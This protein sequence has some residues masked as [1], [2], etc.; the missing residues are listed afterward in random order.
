MNTENVEQTNQSEAEAQNNIPQ[1]EAN[2][3]KQQDVEQNNDAEKQK[4]ESTVTDKEAELLK[5]VMKHKERAKK[6]EEQL[7]LLKKSYGDVAPEEVAELIK[8]RKDE[9]T[10]V[11]EDKGEYERIKKQLV[12]ER[13]NTV[14]TLEKRIQDLE[15]ENADK[16]EV[17]GNLTV[18]HEFNRSKFIAE[19]LVLPPNKARELYGAYFDVVDGVVTAYDKPK[20][21]NERTIL[22]DSQG[23]PLPFD[24]ALE[25]IIGQDPEKDYL[26]K[27][28]VK[29][30]ANSTDKPK[31]GGN[32]TPKGPTSSLEKIESG[33]T[34]LLSN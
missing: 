13:N 33:L 4:A 34:S 22:I 30:G 11:L 19:Q 6:A 29:L 2:E 9:E 14:A 21:A 27:S 26:M 15:K 8:K 10:K 20:G 28:K 17:I 12:E 1:T 24:Q 16:D 31:S 5:D 18:G 3:A 32:A 25:R 23:N 7:E